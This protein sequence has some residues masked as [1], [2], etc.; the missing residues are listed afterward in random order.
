MKKRQRQKQREVGICW[1]I[2]QVELTNSGDEG[3]L[4]GECFVPLW[5]ALAAWSLHRNSEERRDEV[6]GI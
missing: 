3:V 5:I 6:V 1:F 4:K 2:K